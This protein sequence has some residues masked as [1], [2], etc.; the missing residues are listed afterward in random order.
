[1]RK[2]GSVLV[3]VNFSF[4]DG[5]F[6][7][8]QC[9]NRQDPARIAQKRRILVHESQKSCNSYDIRQ[10]GDILGRCQMLTV[11][12]GRRKPGADGS[13]IGRMEKRALFRIRS[14]YLSHQIFRLS[15]SCP[16]IPRFFHLNIISHMIPPWRNDGYPLPHGDR[17]RGPPPTRIF[18]KLGAPPGSGS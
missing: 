7:G 13:Q 4:S 5:N 11:P 15:S 1:M 2:K 12:I 3:R 14:Y 17:K 6:P 18:Y 8:Q 9:F 16:I 10:T